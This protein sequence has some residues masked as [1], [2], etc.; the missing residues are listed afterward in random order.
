MMTILN[1]HIFFHL[2]PP[3]LVNL[4]FFVVIFLITKILEVV[5]MIVNCYDVHDCLF[6]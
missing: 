1:R 2:I 5:N 3:F 4:L 6:E